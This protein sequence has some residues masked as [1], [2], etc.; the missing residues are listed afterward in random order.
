MGRQDMMGQPG[1][2]TGLPADKSYLECGL[3]DFLRE[4]IAQMQAAWDR[5][6]RAEIESLA[7][8]CRNADAPYEAGVSFVTMVD[9]FLLSDNVEILELETV[10]NGFL[11]SDHNPVRLRF[12]LR[13]TEGGRE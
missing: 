6:D 7:P 5:L 13:E 12:T 2:D 1:H 8:S 9:G 11:Y 10:D 4:S 3:P